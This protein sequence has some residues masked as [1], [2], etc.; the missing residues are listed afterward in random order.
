MGVLTE[1]QRI[2]A[3]RVDGPL[4]KG[5]M[6]EVYQATHLALERAVAIKVLDP[7]LNV[8]PTFPLRFLREAKAVARL[9]HPNIITIYDFDE[10]GKLAYLVMELAPGGT[11]R[12]R[13][14]QFRTLAEAIEALAPVCEAL[15]FAHD[16]GII[17]RDVKPIN[18]LINERDQPLLADFGL[19]RIVAESLDITFMGS[20]AGSPHYMSPEQALGAED[21]DHR[22]DIYALGI[23]TYEAISGTLPYIG[24]TPL[25]V[26]QQHVS[27]PPPSILAALPG[28]PAALDAAIMRATA[29]QPDARFAS[30][31]DFLAALRSAA[32][33]APDLPIRA[34]VAAAPASIPAARPTAAATDPLVNQV[35][36]GSVLPAT[37]P[38]DAPLRMPTLAELGSI[39]AAGGRSVSAFDE[40]VIL[41]ESA[42]PAASLL[43]ANS[44][45]GPAAALAGT[46]VLPS[47]RR[48]RATSFDWLQW[49]ALGATLV[50]LLAIDA[51][52]VWLWFG[53]RSASG[54]TSFLGDHLPLVTSLLA[55]LALALAVV[56]ASLMR[57]AIF[58]ERHVSMRTYRRLR[59]NHRYIGYTAAL[60]AISVE[61][62]TW[63]HIFGVGLPAVLSVLDLVFGTALLVTAVTKVAVVRFVPAYR[64]YLPWFG[65]ALLV[66][67]LLVFGLS[68]AA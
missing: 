62:L 6:A 7:A 50:L 46:V 49:F 22:T 10:Q 2:G 37:A 41:S 14:A 42:R 32:A 59:Q 45:Q 30:A 20:S 44:G 56:N 9:S 38:S 57:V 58:R 65:V 61:V 18:V 33:E 31:S 52:G 23:L 64:R 66:L 63:T 17:H 67:F 60:I 40:T 19:A 39:E 51:A 68:L 36:N 26:M 47:P 4:G 55:G 28:A 34:G 35:L 48:Q 8:D 27:S 29:K 21:I 24:T 11:L 15:Q 5:G 54:I 13:A 16:R 25:A 53:G 43:R 3:Y 1:G 12:E